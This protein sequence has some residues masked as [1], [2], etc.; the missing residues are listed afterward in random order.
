MK[1]TIKSRLSDMLKTSEMSASELAKAAQVD[2]TTIYRIMNGETE[3][4]SRKTLEPLA[5]AL[6]VSLDY[7][8]KGIGEKTPVTSNETLL[9]RALNK[10]EAQID[11]QNIM[12]DNLMSIIMK[13]DKAGSFLK[14]LNQKTA[15]KATG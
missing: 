4:P 5:K 13:S 12:I 8:H 11:R 7:L 2:Y 14:T 15:L 1:N 3:N 10:L 9:E 6:N